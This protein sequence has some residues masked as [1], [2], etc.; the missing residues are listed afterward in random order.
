MEA[1]LLATQ[2]DPENDWAATQNRVSYD[3]FAQ[4]PLDGHLD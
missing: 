1:I 4:A 2:R 3:A